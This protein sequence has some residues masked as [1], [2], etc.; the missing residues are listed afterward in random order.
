MPPA[1]Q[2][3]DILRIERIGQ[4]IR[5]LDASCRAVRDLHGVVVDETKNTFLIQTS[6][7]RKRVAKHG[8]RFA[9]PFGMVEG[10]D[11]QHAPSERLKRR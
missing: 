8:A 3:Q 11:I 6:R 5:V 9:F 2:K 1:R 4:T 10:N 7:G